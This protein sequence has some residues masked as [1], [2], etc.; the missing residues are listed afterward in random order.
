[1]TN[2][3]SILTRRLATVAAL[4]AVSLPAVASGQSSAGDPRWQGWL[5]CW[6]P[7]IAPLASG[8]ADTLGMRTLDPFA[9]L[10]CVAPSEGASSID[11]ITVADGKV[12][13]RETID[14]SGAE[15]TR[16]LD[17][18]S[19][20]ESARWSGDARRVYLR[21]EYTCPGGLTRKS[22]GVLAISTEGELLDVQQVATGNGKSVRVAR[23]RD[24]GLPA[25]LPLSIVDAITGRAMAVGASRTAAAAPI[26]STE[27]VDASRNLDAAVVQ[28]WLIES[29]QQFSVDAKAIVRLADA[30]VP[31]G[32]T[33]VL[34]ALSYPRVFAVNRATFSSDLRQLGG[35]QLAGGPRTVYADVYPPN[36]G[37]YYNGYYNPYYNG[38]SMYGYS[39]FGYSPYGYGSYGGFGA[40]PY[41]SAPVIVIREG[42]APPHGKVVNGRGYT[43][44]RGSSTEPSSARSEPRSQPASSSSGSGSSSSGS[45]SSG[46]E[47]KAHP[48]P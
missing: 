6:R 14:A 12:L 22:N 36:V 46:E 20:V 42:S 28:A 30:G 39:P 17:G 48:K 34:V 32:V 10:L 5:G 43:R 33:D 41:G 26:T 4:L 27:I 37:G 29:G 15:R 25:N 2:R 8:E 23:Y 7:A 19:G 24:A 3:I 21:S 44:D 13:A 47:R 40:Y 38:Y 9:P 35:A 31:S 18:C 16:T 45:S 11:M 1:M